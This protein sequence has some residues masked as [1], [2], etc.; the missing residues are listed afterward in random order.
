MS[1]RLLLGTLGLLVAV[2]L[3][4]L[5]QAAKPLDAYPPAARQSFT[6]GE[7]L[8]DQKR[9]KEAA[10]A[11]NEALRLGMGDFPEIYVQLAECYRRLEQHTQVVAA[12]S[13]LIEEFD[14]SSACRY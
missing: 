7:K 3:A 13:R 5:A 10:E 9:Y 14:L 6:Q 2:V 1:H 4:G 12:C 8:R 11:F